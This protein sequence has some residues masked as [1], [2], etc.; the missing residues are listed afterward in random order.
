M[1]RSSRSQPE[2]HQYTQL[3]AHISWSC[4]FYVSHSVSNFQKKIPTMCFQLE[5]TRFNPI[6]EPCTYL[7]IMCL[8]C[9]TFSFKLS[10]NKNSNNV[11]STWKNKIQSNHAF[12]MEGHRTYVISGWNCKWVIGET[13]SQSCKHFYQQLS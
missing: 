10:K 6:M 8:L 7:M 3:F 11:L 12:K 2:W 5:K 13:S 9:T 1:N 4:V